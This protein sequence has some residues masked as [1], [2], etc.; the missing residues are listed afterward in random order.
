MNNYQAQ[1][2]HNL[3]SII[4][5]FTSIIMVGF[6]VGMVRSFW[7][8]ERYRLVKR[9]KRGSLITIEREGSK[10]VIDVTN[11]EDMRD[12]THLLDAAGISWN[13]YQPPELIG[14]GWRIDFNFADLESVVSQMRL[15]SLL[16]EE[17]REHYSNITDVIPR[18]K[19][20]RIPKVNRWFIIPW[21][22][23]NNYVRDSVVKE[24]LYH[25]SGYVDIIIDEGFRIDVPRAHDP[26]DFGWGIYFSDGIGRAYSVGG[27]DIRPGY[28]RVLAVKVDVRKPLYL[29]SPYAIGEPITEGD[30]FM[31]QLRSLYG[32]TVHGLTED[33]AMRLYEQGKTPDEISV[34]RAE[35]RVR[36]AK[37]WAAEIQKAGYDCAVWE[38]GRLWSIGPMEHEVVI[39]NPSKIRIIGRSF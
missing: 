17:P 16:L 1:Q 7:P 6:M 29:K 38:R 22:E 4:G 28:E 36:S 9:T 37:T 30:R 34:I 13:M 39:Y 11:L 20:V 3:N 31:H 10:A 33:E 8:E 23:A 15:S 24:T 12:L 18:I 32:D 21:Q 19:G 5:F 2:I 35:N 14:K 27:I 25:G 26:G